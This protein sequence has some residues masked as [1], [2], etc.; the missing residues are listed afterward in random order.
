MDEVDTAD[1]LIRS[2][3]GSGV[4]EPCFIHHGFTPGA[5]HPLDAGRVLHIGS[6]NTFSMKRFPFF[7]ISALL[8]AS[9]LRVAAVITVTGL[10]TKTSYP[11]AVTYTVANEAGFTTVSNLD[12]QVINASAGYSSRVI[13]YHELNI[14]KTPTAGGTAETAFFQYIIRDAAGREG[15]NADNGLPS[16]VPVPQ[17]DAPAAVLDAQQTLFVVPQQM[18]AGVKV[19]VI[20]RLATNAGG[21][22][23]KLNATALTYEPG[24]ATMTHRIY[25]GA[26][27]GQFPA[28]TTG[29]AKS[30]VL[31]FTGGVKSTRSVQVVAA[32]TWTTLNGSLTTAV[33]VPANSFLH[34]N[35]SLTVAPGGSLTIGA[36]TIVKLDTGVDVEV[37]GTMTVNGTTV[38]PVLFYPATA[39]ARWGGIWVNGA[40]GDLDMTG[41]I[42]TGAC[43]QS[44]W[45][46][47]APHNFGGHHAD[48]PVITFSAL[49]AATTVTLTDTYIIDNVPGQAF[50]GEASNITLSRCIV[51]RATT[52][53]QIDDG[54]VRV[55]DSHFVEINLDNGIFEDDD[56]DGLYMTGGINEM[57][58]SVWSNC[59]D[60]GCDAGSGIGGTMTI[61]SC[62]YD[63]CWHEAMAWSC[64][65]NP[66]RVVNIT[67][68]VSINSGQGVEAGFGAATTG[69][70]VTAT[71]CLFM[72]NA[73]GARFGDNYDWDYPGH[74]TVRN[75]T[76][77]NNL[78]DVWGMNWA[79]GHTYGWTYKEDAMTI[80]NNRLSVPNS[81][82]PTN[83][84]FNP[85]T[86]GAVI[87]PL[88]TSAAMMRG[89]GLTG[90]A[91]QNARTAYGGE[92]TAHLDRPATAAIALPWRV[93]ARSAYDG[94]SEATVA[95]GTV[96]FAAGQSVQKIMFPVLSVPQTTWPWVALV[97]NG[98]AGMC[99]AT[100]L[101]AIHF[102]TFHS[103]ASGSDTL[104]ARD[105]SWRYSDAGDIGAAAWTTAA[106]AEPG[107]KTGNAELGLG[108]TQVTNLTAGGISKKS[109]YYFRK[110]FTVANPAAYTSVTLNLQRDDGAVVYLNGLDVCRSNMPQTGAITYATNASSAQSNA[111]EDAFWPRTWTMAV[112]PNLLQTG[113][114]TIAVEVHQFEN[115]N[116]SDISFNLE[117]F[118]TGAQPLTW[119]AATLDGAMYLLWNGSA[120]LQQSRAL[121][122]WL[123]RPDIRSPWRVEQDGPRGFFR[124][125]Y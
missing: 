26:G 4:P 124:L 47:V 102:M 97:V 123:D 98:Q 41:A 50:H 116:P 99:E 63:S 28:F 114:N 77:V 106:Y 59:K 69:P 29:G 48:Q 18:P 118:A 52:G 117:L 105:G 74:L 3:P 85:A 109:T 13:G 65:G 24:G 82:H 22:I 54:R 100:G 44:N 60:D 30:L 91:A 46:S 43:E 6:T 66:S 14:T 40:S 9:A 101:S 68:T 37:Q 78:R 42:L 49:A 62:W 34:I 51:Q 103:A 67:N 93:I 55:L 11:D 17:V 119:Q 110:K 21:L 79:S 57:I 88:I 94:G 87:A 20:V 71:G 113:E 95:S 81:H 89:F 72:E 75:S 8:A 83:T 10:T 86:D 31:G 121:L 32:P 5:L 35:G 19:P 125:R 38:A 115:G 39:G 76:I 56:N 92:V 96:N 70:Q 107:W 12:G 111:D 64:D 58:R 16:W 122:D 15:G 25:R 90:R 23:A 2:L 108:D 33:N 80:E 104:L 45:L 36:G 27:A 120:T 1:D 84:L 73:V 53:G 7:L 61:D 112:T